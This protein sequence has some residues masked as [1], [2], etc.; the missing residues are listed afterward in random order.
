MSPHKTLTYLGI[1]MMYARGIN[2]NMERTS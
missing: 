1:I 2:K